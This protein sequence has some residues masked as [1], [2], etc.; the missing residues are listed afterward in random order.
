MNTPLGPG[1]LQRRDRII[2]RDLHASDPGNAQALTDLATARSALSSVLASRGRSTGALAELDGSTELLREFLQANPGN[3][4]A[5]RELSRNLLTATLL[6]VQLAS[7]ASA[8]DRR[9][10]LLRSA[11][12]QYTAGRRALRESL[13]HGATVDDSA[14]EALARE[15]ADALAR[16]LRP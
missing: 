10:A 3:L 14:D 11:R 8:G 7:S 5:G 9:A 6:R 12:S 4:R 15:A 2:Y 16:A 1:A 13:A